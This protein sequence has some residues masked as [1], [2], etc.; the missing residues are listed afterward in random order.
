MRERVD[1]ELL[2]GQEQ[3]VGGGTSGGK[4]PHAPMAEPPAA[5]ANVQPPAGGKTGSF[6]TAGLD[7]QQ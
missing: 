3:K 7:K 4:M 1:E 5:A 2:P 6:Q